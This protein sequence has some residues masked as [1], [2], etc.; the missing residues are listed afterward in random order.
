MG[1]WIVGSISFCRIL[2]LGF[3]LE[4]GELLASEVV[5]FQCF[6]VPRPS[7]SSFLWF[8]FRIL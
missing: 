4:S 2:G 7:S 1:F 6:S 8:M 3:K 5:D